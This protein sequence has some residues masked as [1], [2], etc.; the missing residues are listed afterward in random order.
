ML[1]GY[2]K[3]FLGG[4]FTIKFTFL[5]NLLLELKQKSKHKLIIS[6]TVRYNT[7]R[8]VFCYS[9]KGPQIKVGH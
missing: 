8:H 4:I 5:K 3:N 2:L 1:P 9:D 6:N 7:T